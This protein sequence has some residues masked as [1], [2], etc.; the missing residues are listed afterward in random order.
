MSSFYAYEPTAALI[1]EL[2]IQA[3]EQIDQIVGGEECEGSDSR[4][5][6]LADLMEAA[7]DRLEAMSGGV[8]RETRALEPVNGGVPAGQSCPLIQHETDTVTLQQLR[9]THALFDALF[10]VMK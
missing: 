7:A 1:A 8:P 10:G 4:K 9:A 5:T 6:M 3:A 2:R